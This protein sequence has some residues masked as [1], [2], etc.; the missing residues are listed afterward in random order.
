MA[1]EAVI[2]DAQEGQQ[3]ELSDYLKTPV[4]V[5]DK[6]ITA[7]GPVLLVESSGGSRYRVRAVDD[8]DDRLLLEKPQ[9]DG[10]SAFIRLTAQVVSDA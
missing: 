2:A 6:R 3:L 8:D 4:T 5:A 1:T 10:W 7:D 9:D